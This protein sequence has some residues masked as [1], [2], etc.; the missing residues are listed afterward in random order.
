MGAMAPSPFIRVRW[1]VSHDYN[2]LESKSN[3]DKNKRV[4]DQTEEDRRTTTS[5]VRNEFLGSSSA[6]CGL[7]FS[8]FDRVQGSPLQV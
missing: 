8:S 4:I 5:V 6:S 1:P 2:K 3:K 7:P